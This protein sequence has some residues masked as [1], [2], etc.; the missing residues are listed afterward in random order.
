MVTGPCPPNYRLVHPTGLTFH[1][2]SLRKRN[3]NSG[4]ASGMRID[5]QMHLLDS[6]PP[7]P[8]LFMTDVTGK[9]RK[10]PPRVGRTPDVLRKGGPMKD[11]SKY[12]RQP[13][14]KRRENDES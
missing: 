8:V 10:K 5:F 7:R 12:D 1:T 6:L 4:T 3:A 2:V 13:K 9:K 11:R 14:H